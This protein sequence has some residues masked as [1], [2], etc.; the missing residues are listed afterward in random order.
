MRAR[1]LLSVATILAILAPFPAAAA[2]APGENRLR[3]ALRTATQQARALEDEKAQWQAREAQ[4]KKEIDGL[5]EEIALA[6]KRPAR[7]VERDLSTLNERLAEAGEARGRL[8][9]DLDQCQAEVREATE[10]GRAAE[11]E[12][13]A[14]QAQATSLGARATECAAR[15]ARMYATGKEILQWLFGSA[16]GRE[17]LDQDPFLGLKRV[18]LENAAQDYEDKLLEQRVSP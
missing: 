5:R 16:G 17:I 3:E 6:R 15:N 11:T 9:G 4:Y 14:L 1:H 2:D 13:A 7:N 8:K 18:E 12:R 10:K